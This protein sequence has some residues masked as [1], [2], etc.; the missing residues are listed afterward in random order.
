MPDEI[1]RKEPESV[2][3]NLDAT[4]IIAE[5]SYLREMET[6]VMQSNY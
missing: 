3:L 5:N 4:A 2:D 1:H 6:S